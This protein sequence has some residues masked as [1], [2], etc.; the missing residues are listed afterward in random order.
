M[1][2][3]KIAGTY[4]EKDG[5][6]IAASHDGRFVTKGRTQDEAYGRMRLLLQGYTNLAVKYK[7]LPS[8]GPRPAD[9][10]EVWQLALA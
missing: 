2:I 7:F 6:I 8:E 9:K 3:F 4:K 1:A 10:A 5:W